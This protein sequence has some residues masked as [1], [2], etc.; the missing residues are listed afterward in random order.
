MA[1]GTSQP[2][3]AKETN[4]TFQCPLLTS[5]NYTIWRMRMEVLLGIH[6]V[7]D[8]IDTGLEDAKKNNIV[9]GLLFQSMLQDLVLQMVLLL[10]QPRL[11][12]SKKFLTSLP[13][14]FVHI[15]AA[16][17]QVLDLK[18]TGFEDVV[19]R[20]KAYEERIKE[21]DKANETQEKLLYNRTENSN[22][23]HASNVISLGQATISGCDI[24][25][26]GDFLTMRDS[27]GR[28]L[29][30]VP[31][32][33]NRLY[34]THLKLGNL[35]LCKLPLMKSHGCGTCDLAISDLVR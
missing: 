14:R 16:L 5:T 15:V 9:K 13:R 2:P 7:W 23:N 20:L 19:G 4:L 35:T 34:K 31:R 29:V 18:E 32:S 10:N 6:G 21:E 11:E 25:I 12:K 3:V 1:A 27:C 17:E 24:R 33:A 28:L 8:V 26:R 22:R 30:K